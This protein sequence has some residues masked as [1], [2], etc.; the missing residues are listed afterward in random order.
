MKVL[1]IG[2]GGREHALVWKLRQSPIVEQVYCV[3]GNA[4]IAMEA[5]CIPGDVLSPKELAC[6]AETLDVSLTVVGPEAPLVAGLVDEF[7]AHGRTVLGPTSAAAQLEGSKLFAKQFLQ[8]QNIP[9]A[10]YAVVDAP[11]DISPALASFGFPVVIKADGLAAGKG[12]VIAQDESEATKTITDM[13]SGAFVGQAGR[14]V[15]VE[16][17]LQGPEASYIHLPDGTA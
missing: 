17:F 7:E 11:A 5:S 10:R 16:V 15:V 6:L 4:G 13:L 8:N 3:P 1:V 14:R 2:S 12:V 9:S